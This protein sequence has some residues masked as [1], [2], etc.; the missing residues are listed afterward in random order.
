MDVWSFYSSNNVHCLCS[1]VTFCVWLLGSI[2]INWFFFMCFVHSTD[3]HHIQTG[4]CNPCRFESP[5]G[6]CS[7]IPVIRPLVGPPDS[8]NWWDSYNVAH[9]KLQ[10]FFCFMVCTFNSFHVNRMTYMLLHIPLSEIF[11]PCVV[12]FPVWNVLF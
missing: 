2:T 7:H 9:C 5:L 11:L 3:F 12:L 10:L 8:Q 4:T 6:C 1:R